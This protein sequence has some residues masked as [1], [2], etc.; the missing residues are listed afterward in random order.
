MRA[1]SIG[2]ALL[3]AATTLTAATITG[4]VT[5]IAD[6]DSFTLTDARQRSTRVRIQGVDAPER[7]QSF[8]YASRK[9]LSDMLYGR[10]IV[11]VINKED[12]YGRIV[13]KVMVEGRDAGLQQIRSGLAWFYVHY[14]NEMSSSDR[15]AYVA[16]Q[17]DARAAR[18]GLWSEKDPI[19][20]WRFRRESPQR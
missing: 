20:P 11:V 2:F 15:A 7:R 9:S 8:S 12:Q 3:A 13:G 19:P 1:L 17:R 18:R 14:A 6:G 5:A 4:R 16:A 10:T